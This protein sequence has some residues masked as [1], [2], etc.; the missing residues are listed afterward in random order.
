MRLAGN[1]QLS[2]KATPRCAPRFLCFVPPFFSRAVDVDMGLRLKEPEFPKWNPGSW[3]QGPKPAVCPSCLILATAMGAA[4]SCVRLRTFLGHT[5]THTHDCNLGCRLILV[6]PP[7]PW[8]FWGTPHRLR[9]HM[10]LSGG[11]PEHFGG[12]E[13]QGLSRE[14]GVFFVSVCMCVCVCFGRVALCDGF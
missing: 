2:T 11:F 13:E 6:P 8:F 4:C 12:A 7:P 10:D 5:H 14:S 3:K 9:N 1:D